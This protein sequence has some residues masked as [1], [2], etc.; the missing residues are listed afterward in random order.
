MTHPVN[1]TFSS[2]FTAGTKYFDVIR[3]IFIETVTLFCNISSFR[4][5]I[6]SAIYPSPLCIFCKQR[7]NH[8]HI[9]LGVLGTHHLTH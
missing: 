1:C 4:H 6:H 7:A 9:M 2:V 5:A 3:G 8:D